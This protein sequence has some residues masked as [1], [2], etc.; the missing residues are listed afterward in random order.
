VT[1]FLA[2]ALFGRSLT[3]LAL[4]Y[5]SFRFEILIF[6]LAD[7]NRVVITVC[8]PAEAT[9]GYRTCFDPTAS[10]ALIVLDLAAEAALLGLNLTTEAA[11]SGLDFFL[12]S[13][14]SWK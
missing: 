4:S 8:F 1:V 11:L 10:A 6:F 14:F 12:L 9:D 3:F 13:L 2:I 7:C 5:F